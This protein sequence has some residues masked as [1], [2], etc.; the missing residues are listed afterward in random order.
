MQLQWESSVVEY[1][2]YLW[3]STRVHGN[4][5]GVAATSF[6]PLSRDIPLYGPKFIPP[7][8]MDLERR[9]ATPDITPQTMYLRPLRVVHPFYFHQRKFHQCPAC[10]S[11]N[12]HW[13]CWTTT[14]HREVHGTCFPENAIGYQLRCNDCE[15]TEKD[16]PKGDRAPYCFAT[17][18][19]IFWARYEPW[20][21]PGEWQ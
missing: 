1:V 17:T 10:D 3:K 12:T 15:K 9:S 2:N 19:A 13:E 18:S 14:G 20:E 16:K 5:K 11:S 8:Y 6:K 7:S 21:V 4:A